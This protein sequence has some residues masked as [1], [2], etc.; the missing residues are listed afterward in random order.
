MLF[1]RDS[2]WMFES[3][4]LEGQFKIMRSANPMV[5]KTTPIYLAACNNIKYF[6]KEV[7]LHEHTSKLI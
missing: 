3:R 2:A 7:R 1:G 6:L 5:A 4:K